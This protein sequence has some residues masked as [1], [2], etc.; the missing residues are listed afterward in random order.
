MLRLIGTPPPS[1]LTFSLSTAATT[2]VV[3]LPSHSPLPSPA[4]VLNTGQSSHMLAGVSKPAD[5]RLFSFLANPSCPISLPA[6]SHR[7]PALS[8]SLSVPSPTPM[9]CRIWQSFKTPAGMSVLCQWPTGVTSCTRV[10][11]RLQRK[12]GEIRG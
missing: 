1:V 5:G 8:L 7:P 11:W 6:E 2:L 4:P 3:F 12:G 9:R 10:G